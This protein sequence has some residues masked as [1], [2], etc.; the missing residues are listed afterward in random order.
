MIQH[1]SCTEL[2]CT[3]I[4]VSPLPHAI[5]VLTL[6]LVHSLL[7]YP[8]PSLLHPVDI[9]I[10]QSKSII[11]TCST[12]QE[13]LQADDEETRFWIDILRSKLEPVKASFITDTDLKEK[14]RALRNTVLC[15]M[16]LINVMWIVLLFSLN[17]PISDRYKIPNQALTLLFLFLYTVI[18]LVQF[19]AM[20]AHRCVTLV[21]YLARVGPGEE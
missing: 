3:Y 9:S 16:L 4:Y 19:F 13:P 14:L 10:S 17:I 18:L 5:A 21:H 12:Q 15:V 8:P 2:L 20:I 7:F 1:F 6:L 11:E